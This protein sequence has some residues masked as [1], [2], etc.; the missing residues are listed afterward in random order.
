[1]GP[2]ILCVDHDDL[3]LEVTRIPLEQHGYRVM[4]ADNGSEA[5]SLLA[6]TND[7]VALVLMDWGLPNGDNTAVVKKLKTL[8]P[9]IRVL[10]TSGYGTPAVLPPDARKHVAGF[11]AKPY[12][13]NELIRAV[14]HALRFVSGYGFSRAV[15]S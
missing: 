10:V 9:N 11:L 15:A 2:T 7:D 4:T 13:P 5:I 8:R 1:M 14:R 12:L 6:Q 3:V